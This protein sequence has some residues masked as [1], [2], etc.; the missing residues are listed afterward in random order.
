MS[1]L[2]EKDRELVRSFAVGCAILFVL[3]LLGWAI[4]AL[5]WLYA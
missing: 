5:F 1:P 3:F 2:N 4:V